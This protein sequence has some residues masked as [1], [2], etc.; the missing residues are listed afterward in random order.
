[1]NIYNRHTDIGLERFQLTGARLIA[2]ATSWRRLTSR[3]AITMTTVNT[4]VIDR[5]I[6]T[7]VTTDRSVTSHADD[8][9][10]V[11]MSAVYVGPLTTKQCRRV[12]EWRRTELGRVRG[13]AASTV[14]RWV[15]GRRVTESRWKTATPLY[16][17]HAPVNRFTTETD[18]NNRSSANLS[19]PSRKV[20]PFNGDT[21]ITW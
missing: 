11:N 1:M 21:F 5:V 10:D 14:T 16:T 6:I 9:S 8:A 2:S 19:L 3:H 18:R 17:S 15:Y 20:R 7:A 13:R 12:V 4:G